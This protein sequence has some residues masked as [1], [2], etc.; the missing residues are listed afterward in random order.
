M[1]ANLPLEILSK[2]KE[3]YLDT[4]SR[5]NLAFTSKFLWCSEENLYWLSYSLRSFYN[6]RHGAVLF[7]N[8]LKCL[9]IRF[10]GNPCIGGVRLECEIDSKSFQTIKI[11]EK[12]IRS[13]WHKNVEFITKNEGRVILMSTS[14]TCHKMDDRNGWEIYECTFDRWTNAL[15]DRGFERAKIELDLYDMFPYLKLLDVDHHIH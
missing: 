4:R 8:T 5:L 9:E 13:F 11:W 3:N 14:S 10:G 6:V 12:W 7:T 15:N 1:L 2:I